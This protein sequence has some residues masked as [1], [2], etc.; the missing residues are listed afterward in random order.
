MYGTFHL[1]SNLII[2]VTIF[3]FLNSNNFQAKGDI[4]LVLQGH[5]HKLELSLENQEIWS[6][7]LSLAR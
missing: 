4:L 5:R 1:R 3:F 7:N 6:Y 2:R